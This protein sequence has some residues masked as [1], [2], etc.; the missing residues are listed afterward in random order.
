MTSL[1][2]AISLTSPSLK[3]YFYVQDIA[4]RLKE[5]RSGVTLLEYSIMIGLITAL[6]VGTVKLAGTWVAT[7]WTTLSTNVGGF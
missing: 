2:K 3:A 7:Q 6:A 4:R 1:S 5:D